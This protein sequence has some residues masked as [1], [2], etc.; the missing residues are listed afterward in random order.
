[1]DLLVVVLA[2][3]LLLLDRPLAHGLL[4]VA[5]GV[6]AADHE[7]NLARG[8]GG[9]GGVSVLDVGEDLLAVFLEL[10]D[11]GKVEPLVLGCGESKSQQFLVT[12]IAA[13]KQHQWHRPQ[14]NDISGIRK[15]AYNLE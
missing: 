15:G 11:Q 9:N 6:K 4:E 14:T 12:Q 5:V 10:G 3:L 7:A 13:N 8:V 1:M 2:E